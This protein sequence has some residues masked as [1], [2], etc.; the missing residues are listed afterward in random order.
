MYIGSKITAIFRNVTGRRE[1]D[2]KC[3]GERD[4]E[5]SV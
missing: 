2:G 5:K 4:G 1:K 3:K